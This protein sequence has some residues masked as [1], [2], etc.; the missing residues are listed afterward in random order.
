MQDGDFIKRLATT[1][2]KHQKDL[3]SGT[4]RNA[5]TFLGMTNQ[6]MACQI[7]HS[8]ESRNPVQKSGYASHVLSAYSD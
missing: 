1:Q 2:H 8:G 3:D 5:P 4:R 6:E 7:P